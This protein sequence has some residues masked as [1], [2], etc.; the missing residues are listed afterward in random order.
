MRD[1]DLR[2]EVD[3]RVRRDSDDDRKRAGRQAT[4]SA[5]RYF[6]FMRGQADTLD[7]CLATRSSADPFGILTSI[8]P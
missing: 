5:S 6:T 8:V 2:I 1:R 7:G 3:V 4:P